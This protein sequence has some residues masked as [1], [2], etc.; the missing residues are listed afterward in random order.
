MSLKSVVTLCASRV[1]RFAGVSAAAVVFVTASPTVAAQNTE[2]KQITAASVK[3]L[4]LFAQPGDATPA[5]T[6]TPDGMPWPILEEKQDFFRVKVGGADF[7]VDSMQV[8]A[9]RSVSAQCTV[10]AGKAATPVG[11]TPGAGKDACAVR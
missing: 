8:R 3:Q 2:G 9:T 4:P 1:L 5:K 10:L 11:A 7:W 6:V